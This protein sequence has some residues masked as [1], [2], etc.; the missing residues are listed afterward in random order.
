MA[1]ATWDIEWFITKQ[2]GIEYKT[3]VDGEK[4]AH[5]QRN[6]L[7]TNPDY[8][9]VLKVPRKPANFIALRQFFEARKGKWQEFYWKW[10]TAIDPSGDNVTYLVR[11]DIDKFVFAGDDIYWAVP[12]VQV[13]TSE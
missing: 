5:E 8:D 3:D 11:L 6:A 10:D 13:M 4:T 7:L 1:V 12:I 2:F 9:W